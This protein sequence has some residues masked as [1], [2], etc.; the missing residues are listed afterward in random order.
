MA[1]GLI[2]RMPPVLSFVGKPGCGKT[3]LMEKLIL[4]LSQ[5]GYRIGTIKHHIHA[6]EMDT[7]GKDTWRHKQAGAC[8]VALASPNGLGI[9]RDVDCDPLVNELVARYF[10]DADMVLAE[11]YKRFAM[12]KIEV[13]RS[14][15]HAAPLKDR[16]DTWIAFVSDVSLSDS[17]NVPCFSPDDIAAIGDFIID[18]FLSSQ[19]TQKIVLLIDGKPVELSHAV[20][21]SILSALRKPYALLGQATPPTEILL[22]IRN[23]SRIQP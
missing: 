17:G 1:T 22:S 23:A 8:T 12:P 14:S 21:N 9:I 20:E 3:T 7:P 2:S 15:M 5:K 18:R 6:F 16:D 11:G 13:F 4:F 10:F 19:Q